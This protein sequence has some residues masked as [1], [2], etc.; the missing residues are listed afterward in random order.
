VDQSQEIR[1]KNLRT[2][3]ILGTIALAFAIGFALRRYFQ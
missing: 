1:R 2:G 3:L